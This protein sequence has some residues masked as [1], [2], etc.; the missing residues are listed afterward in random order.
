MQFSAVEDRQVHVPPVQ[1]T[2][3]LVS[4]LSFGTACPAEKAMASATGS[5]APQSAIVKSLGGLE[6]KLD[7]LRVPLRMLLGQ[8]NLSV[9]RFEPPTLYS[10]SIVPGGFDV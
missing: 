4:G 10:H 3:P 6:N 8:R 7:M 9:T 1:L 2:V 5:A